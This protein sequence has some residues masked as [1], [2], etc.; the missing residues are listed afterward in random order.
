MRQLAVLLLLCAPAPR[1]GD[2]ITIVE[3]SAV[4]VWEPSTKTEHFIRRATFKG[5]GRDFGFLVPTPSEPALAEVDDDIFDALEEHTRRKT[6]YTKRREL[7]WTPLLFASR[8]KG[9]TMTGAA[10]EAVQV[11]ATKKLA[12]Y[13]AAVLDASDATALQQWLS[14]HGYAASD[15][16]TAWLDAY[17]RQRWKITAFKVDPL[18][19]PSARTS[20][21]KMTF[22][23]ERPFFP[24]REPASQ[25][26][27]YDTV[28]SL[29]VWFLGPERVSGT[30]GASGHWPGVLVWS[31]TLADAFRNELAK[32][33]GVALS[34]SMRLSAYVDTSSVRSGGDEL[35]F[36]RNAVQSAYIP[37]PHVVEEVEKTRI[38][39]D[40][41]GAIS[42]IAIISAAR[43]KRGGKTEY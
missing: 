1:H 6:I 29:R 37:P 28:R 7:D 8:H 34:P 26:Q 17:V 38:P 33:A 19:G 3:E 5:K 27:S 41:V 18:Q 11:L 15:D 23:T 13:E 9:E 14:E 36:S 12:G 30:V 39:A 2:E 22:A 43:W 4:I 20:A 42:L 10:P 31:N 32:M 16:L 24:Y 40:L 35:F 21:V 25:R